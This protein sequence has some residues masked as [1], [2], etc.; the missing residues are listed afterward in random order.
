[1]A[2]DQDELHLRQAAGDAQHLH[3][4]LAA[5]HHQ[6]GGS[7]RLQAQ[8]LQRLGAG[9]R[10]QRGHG[11]EGRAQDHA[12]D[13][14]HIARRH[15][16]GQGLLHRALGAAD[17][18]LVLPRLDPEM[19]RRVGQVGQHRG[20]GRARPR[21]LHRFVEAAVEVGDQRDH[22]V[23]PRLGPVRLQQ[24]H[25]PGVGP[26]HRGLQQLE[27]LRQAQGPAARQAAVVDILGRHAG[28]APEAVL[29]IQH[30]HQVHQPHLQGSAMSLLQHGLQ[31]LRRGPVATA[32]VEI[33][34]VHG[35]GHPREGAGWA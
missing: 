30:R 34:Q 6:A 3:G 10:I 32:R 26:A 28:Q 21:G 12:R 1:M 5:E 24:A 11:V 31:G 16:L 13:A 20:A 15:A 19:R 27:L 7:A 2:A 22:H 17:D 18:P 9:C 23:R 14:V 33:H 35:S 25:E 8:C 29:R 4:A